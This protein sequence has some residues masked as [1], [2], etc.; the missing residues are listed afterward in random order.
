MPW[1]SEKAELPALMLAE[2]GSPVISMMA[3][4]HR[5][6]M[7]VN[8]QTRPLI[9]QADLFLKVEESFAMALRKG[10]PFGHAMV[11]WRPDPT[12]RPCP[13]NIVVE[14]KNDGDRRRSDPTYR[15]KLSLAKDVYAR[16]NIDFF[17]IVRS[18]DI[19]CIDMRQIRAIFLDNKTTISAVDVGRAVRYLRQ[20]GGIGKLGELL[21]CLGSGA[22]AR[23]IANA[24]HIRRCISI[25]LRQPR[26]DS[27]EVTLIR[28]F[29]IGT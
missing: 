18:R 21:K 10:V 13:V 3:Q 20:A 28:P 25:D 2:V 12:R 26:D 29:G 11:A 24:L 8:E 27:A 19:D 23:A 9:Y 5:V 17:E 4:P 1:E 16:E 15:A 6:E 7:D 14:V 22:A